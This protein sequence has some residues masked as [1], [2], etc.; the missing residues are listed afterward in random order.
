[1]TSNYVVQTA[2]DSFMASNEV[3]SGLVGLL[4]FTACFHLLFSQYF[5]NRRREEAFASYFLVVS[6]KIQGVLRQPITLNRFPYLCP[7]FHVTFLSSFL[8]GE[9]RRA[10]PKNEKKKSK[11]GNDAIFMVPSYMVERRRHMYDAAKY[12][13]VNAN[14]N[15]SNLQHLR[16]LKNPQSYIM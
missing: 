5:D 6:W 16:P 7:I 14:H 3:A 2:I 13:F 4:V 9:R 10:P 15:H 11:R 1:M 8:C 12:V